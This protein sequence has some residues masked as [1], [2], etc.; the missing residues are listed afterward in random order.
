MSEPNVGESGA[1]P[2][3]GHRGWIP[4]LGVLVG[5]LVVHGLLQLWLGG[6]PDRDAWFH[7]RLAHLIATG[8]APWHGLDFPWLTH[9][10]YA[11]RPM[12]W[13]LLWHL[14][15]APFT[16]VAGPVAGLKAFAAVQAALLTATFHHVLRRLDVRGALA[17]TALLL[18][19][20]PEWLFRLHFG[21]PTPLAVATLLVVL[22]LM[23]RRRD[24]MA[25]L[26]VVV[27]LLVY[28]VPAPV[29]MIAGAAWLGR[30][31]EDGRPDWRAACTVAIGGVVGVLAQPGLWTGG[32]FN[33]WELMRGS[34]AVAA[35]GGEVVSPG[36]D[37]IVLPLPRE[38]GAPG[39][40]KFLTELWVPLAA[41]LASAGLVLRARRDAGAVATTVLAVA[42]L[43]GTARSGR[44]FE[45]WHVLALL[46]AAVAISGR[47]ATGGARAHAQAVGLAAVILGALT[48]RGIA[49][50]VEQHG[51]DAGAEVRPALAAIERRSERGDVVWHASWD[52]FA[53]LF[54]FA[55]DLRYVAGMDPWWM[56]AHD[57]D[58]ARAY[59]LAGR[60]ALDEIEL[61]EALTERFGARFALIWT[62]AEDG[63]EGARVLSALSDQLRA[64]SWAELIHED[65]RTLAFELHVTP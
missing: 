63:P 55:P 54:H 4:G 52:D 26:A 14:L 27:S 13:S 7:S 50:L 58:D 45:Y 19:A 2:G 12:D 42:G 47:R 25:A 34:L 37:V 65:E 32:T 28:Q 38:L 53:P 57:P 23:L 35:A 49:P 16:A 43:L 39:L 46:A 15:L 62:Q 29:V 6:F 22:D 30:W 33:L 31:A 56:V 10:A 64:A 5:A 60:G 18:A 1:P 41:T 61:Q 11:D 44:F 51:T 21:R 3:S 48:L 40:G 8:G 17:W 36:G 20:S 59:D 9:S 24:R